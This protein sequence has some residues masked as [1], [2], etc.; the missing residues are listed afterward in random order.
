MTLDDKYIRED[1]SNEKFCEYYTRIGKMRE[2]CLAES[3]EIFCIYDFTEEFFES[4]IY[5]EFFLE[6]VDSMLDLECESWCMFDKFTDL[7]DNLWYYVDK[8]P[9]Q[10]RYK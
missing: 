6:I 3:L 4:Q 9:Y 10:Y 7:T 2:C 1:Q 8:E 5:F